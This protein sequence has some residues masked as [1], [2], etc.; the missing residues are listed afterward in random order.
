MSFPLVN[1][2]SGIVHVC[3]TRPIKSGFLVCKIQSTSDFILYFYGGGGG[4]KGPE[5]GAKGV[6]VREGG[7][8]GK[9]EHR[10]Y[11]RPGFRM[12]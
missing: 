4:G 1:K 11:L 7:K 2:V 9:G 3:T 10:I 12:Q 6:N 8:G 5:R